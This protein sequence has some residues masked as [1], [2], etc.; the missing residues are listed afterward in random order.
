MPPAALVS[1]NVPT[2]S[3]AVS[4]AYVPRSL[5]K[6]VRD[7]IVGLIDSIKMGDVRDFRNFM[8]AVIDERAFKKIGGYID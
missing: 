5:W 7:R 4:R 8:G 1:T 2:P 6:E 3:S